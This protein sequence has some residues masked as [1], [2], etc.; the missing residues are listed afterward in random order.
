MKLF[1]RNEKYIAHYKRSADG[2]FVISVLNNVNLTGLPAPGVTTGRT[3][4]YTLTPIE[5]EKLKDDNN[6][7][8]EAELK[9]PTLFDF[10]INHS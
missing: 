7:I 1:D 6:L 4:A 8:T 9:Q 2:S 5:F 10:I 3:S